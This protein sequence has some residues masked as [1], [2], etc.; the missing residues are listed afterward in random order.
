MSSP[1]YWKSLRMIGINSSLDFLEAIW[2]WT[3]VLGEIFDYWFSFI[4]SNQ[5]VH[6]F[7]SSWFSLGR[8]YVPRSLFLS[9]HISHYYC[10]SLP[11]F[12]FEP[13]VT[14]N[15][16]YISSYLEQ[17]CPIQ[18]S[19]MMVTLYLHCP[20]KWLLAIIWLLST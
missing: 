9:P 4:T 8:Y 19:V 7:S 12:S 6:I 18:L 16:S 15:Q 13:D 1:V 2:S 20:V 10:L 3:F 5:P 14:V 17:H 11:Y